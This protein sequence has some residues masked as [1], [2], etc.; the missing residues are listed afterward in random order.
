MPENMQLIREPM[1]D[2]LWYPDDK[3]ALL[4]RIHQSLSIDT[5]SQGNMVF[6]PSGPLDQIEDALG[7]AF[8]RLKGGG[9]SRA[10]LVARCTV[11]TRQRIYLPESNVFRTPLGE[12]F[13]DAEAVSVMLDSSMLIERYDLPHLQENSLELPLVYLQYRFP[14]LPV[15]PVLV[16][17]TND[18]LF[19]SLVASVRLMTQELTGNTL[20]ILCDA[21]VGTK[22]ETTSYQE[23]LT[24]LLKTRNTPDILAS[25]TPDFT[26]GSLILLALAATLMEDGKNPSYL[27]S[28]EGFL[29]I[30]W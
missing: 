2:G 29:S 17:T 1:L 19:R 15:V 3:E 12:S 20:F 26:T 11:E 5:A 21:E 28:K 9:F 16:G 22:V 7:W 10:V 25:A 27:I 23:S 8:S 4:E 6:V 13:L 24:T 14:K 18:T 30:S